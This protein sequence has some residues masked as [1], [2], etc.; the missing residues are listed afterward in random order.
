V[1]E[2]VVEDSIAAH[3]DDVWKVVSD[4]PGV[5]AL[6]GV[7]VE[8]EGEGIGMTRSVAMGES[9]IVER[10]EALD[11]ATYSTSYSIVSGPFP[12][13][14]YYST[15]R[16]APSGDRATRITWSGRFEPDG[17][18]EAEAVKMIEQVYAGGIKGIQKHF[19]T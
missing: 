2:A 1:A 9:K 15:I 6:M 12:L 5:I 3:I 19:T 11:A 17:I 13:T 16:L 10:L 8:S 4:F 18:S 14:G 7:P